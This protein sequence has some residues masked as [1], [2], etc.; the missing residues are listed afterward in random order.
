MATYPCPMSGADAYTASRALFDV[1][2]TRLGDPQMAERP[3]HTVEEFIAGTGRDVLRQAL[4]DHLDARAAAE[5]RLPEVTGA[6]QVPRRRAE[7]GHTRL[8]ST[9]LGQV[10]VT[11]IAYRKPGV[12]SLHPADARLALPD[13][14]YSFPLQQAVVHE[15][16]TGALRQARDG[17]ERILGARVGTRQ[18]MQITTDAARDVRDFYPQ[19]P[20]PTPATRPD[21]QAGPR[22]L[23]V[24]SIDATG[25]NMIDS[26]LRESPP[27]RDDGPRPPSAQL[28]CRE[29]TGR[30][31]MAVVT[32]VYDAAPAIRCPADVMPTDATERATRRP[33]PKAVNREV[34]ASIVDSTAPMTRRLFDRAQ[35]RDPNH[36]RRWIV[37]VDGNNHQIDR[38]NAEAH[39][40]G[41]RIN[42]ILDFVHVLEYLWKAAEDLH[43]TQPGRAAFV[44]RTA[45]DLL[46][47]HPARVIADLKSQ[48]D[49]VTATGDTAPGLKRCIGYLTAKQPYLIYRIALT[50]GWPIATGVI[51]GACRYL[52]KD[53]LAITG[54]RWSLPGAEAVLL[55]RAVI[56]NG[57][58]DAYWKYHLQQEHQ[59]THTSRY[60]HQYDL[61]A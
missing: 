57:D 40:R 50:M 20:V 43:P 49:T 22:D 14:R 12:S 59:R 4:Q 27:G 25:V 1:L 38:I 29:R 18:L 19:H 17:L 26:G 37:L 51:E 15:T 34:D 45:R 36:L 10:E 48:H 44:A 53:R 32:A 35:Q 41:V 47:H 23:L 24:L 61:A 21:G 16:V 56:T 31:R 46:E 2:I 6:D 58:F 9:T 55:L 5:Q 42:L 60:Q 8:L 7:P 54:A 39:T 52:V 3:E 33:G 28:S 30:T 11:R 13:G